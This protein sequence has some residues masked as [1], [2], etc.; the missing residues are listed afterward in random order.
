MFPKHSMKCTFNKIPS[1][2]NAPC[3]ITLSNIDGLPSPN[4]WGEIWPK[5]TFVIAV[6]KARVLWWY[7]FTPA[8]MQCGQTFLG[9]TFLTIEHNEIDGKVCAKLRFNLPFTIR[10][11]RVRIFY[12]VKNGFKSTEKSDCQ[13]FRYHKTWDSLVFEDCFL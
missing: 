7:F 2:W 6:V 11:G 10:H 8:K 12:L 3:S 13:R 4:L 5:D 1:W 9:Q